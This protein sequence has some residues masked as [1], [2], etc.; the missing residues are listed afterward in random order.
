MR[1]IGLQLSGGGI[2]QI[3][4]LGCNGA[5]HLRGLLADIAVPVQGLADGRLGYSALP[6]NILQGYHPHTS[7]A[8][9]MQFFLHFRGFLFAKPFS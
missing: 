5:D 4:H 6:G 3:I 9:E 1:R 8:I 7:L 2:R